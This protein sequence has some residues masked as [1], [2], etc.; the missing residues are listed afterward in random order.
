MKID[1][2]I[3][4]DPGANGGIVT[5]RPGEKITSIKMPK[6]LMELKSYL[7]WAK[8]V[9][10]PIIFLE[11]LSVRPDDIIPGDGGANLGKL[12]RIQKMMANYEQLKLIISLCEIP[13][14]MVHPM[15]WQNAL[16]LRT[17]K[18]EEK[19][20]RKRRYKDVA[21]QLYPELKATLWN[22]DATLIMHFGRYIL[23]NDPKWVK[24]NLPENA[25]KLLL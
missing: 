3:G 25:Q 9:S 5:W 1:C 19:S 22:S 6:D 8:S 14:V 16:K 24:K 13:Y 18:K 15:K 12:Y 4:I 17:G 7:D 10:N 2:I 20:E 23:V 21:S 11:K